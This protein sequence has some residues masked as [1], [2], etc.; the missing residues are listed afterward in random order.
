MS[1]MDEQSNTPDQA[2]TVSPVAGLSA[3]QWLRQARERAGLDL[4]LLSALL[5]VP[6]RQLQALEADQHDQLMGTAFVRSLTRSI[7]KHLN[8]DPQP[9]LDLLPHNDT[10]LGPE[11]DSLGAADVPA[12][13]GLFHGRSQVLTKGLALLAVLLVLGAAALYWKSHTSPLTEVGAAVAVPQEAPVPLSVPAANN[14]AASAPIE[15]QAPVAA[16]LTLPVTLTVPAAQPT[17]SKAQ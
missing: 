14:T 17:D 5:K 7:C 8:V 13:S 11:K 16:P 1:P 10:R 4:G 2:P 12:L 3:G 9:A 15:G 6:V